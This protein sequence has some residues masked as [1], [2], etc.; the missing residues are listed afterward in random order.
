MATYVIGDIHNSIKKLD[1]LLT[2][3][4]P[5]MQDQIFLLGDGGL[6]MWSGGREI[7]MYLSGNRREILR[8]RRRFLWSHML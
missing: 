7:S 4:S 8:I 6:W 3:I 1:N 5:S 2:L